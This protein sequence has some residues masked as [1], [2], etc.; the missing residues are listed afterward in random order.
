VSEGLISN[1]RAPI[2]GDRILDRDIRRRLQ[3]LWAAHENRVEVWEIA[4]DIVERPLHIVLFV[5]TGP[6][7]Q[8]PVRVAG[9]FE[10]FREI[11]IPPDAIRTETVLVDRARDAALAVVR[12]G[13]TGLV[14]MGLAPVILAAEPVAEP[15]PAR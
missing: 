14:L 6:S 9:V 13:A 15:G 2:I 3:Q 7:E 5:W 1:W 12:K 11:A 4:G 8:G 10:V